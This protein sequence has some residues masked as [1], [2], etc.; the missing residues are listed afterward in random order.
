MPMTG[1]Y[2]FRSMLNISVSDLLSQ[3]KQ[4]V[5]SKDVDLCHRFRIRRKKLFEDAIREFRRGFPMNG[6][7]KVTFI[8]EP[9]VDT[10]GPLREFLHLLLKEI[11]G[12]NTLFE[13]EQGRSPSPNLVEVDK[14][15]FVHVGKIVALSLVH[16]GPAPSFFTKAAVD[17]LLHGLSGVVATPKDVTD[18]VALK[19]I[20]KVCA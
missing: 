18:A 14:N 16:G 19:A 11:A 15:T 1:L 2:M 13:G 17:Y 10:G 9:A 20:T 7:I 6:S 8:G 5:I 12:N 4:K 3:H